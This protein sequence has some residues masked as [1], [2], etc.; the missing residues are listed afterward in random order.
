MRSP[1]DHVVSIA[2]RFLI[3]Y[4]LWLPAQLIS[5]LP[6]I[7]HKLGDAVLNALLTDLCLEFRQELSV[8]FGCILQLRP[9]RAPGQLRPCS[10]PILEVV[11]KDAAVLPMNLTSPLQDLFKPQRA[12]VLKARRTD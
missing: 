4:H 3:P 9:V 2:G 1:D 7:Q 12:A 10:G 8:F 6:P 11:T 5:W